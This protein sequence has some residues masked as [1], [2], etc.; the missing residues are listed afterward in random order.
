M[1]VCIKVGISFLINRSLFIFLLCQ[2]QLHSPCVRSCVHPFVGT[3][4]V[5]SEGV[6]ASITAVLNHGDIWL[7]VGVIF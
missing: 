4:T 3:S 7:T 1:E 5:C 6:C 2:M